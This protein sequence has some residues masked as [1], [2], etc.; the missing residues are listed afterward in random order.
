MSIP[1]NNSHKLFYKCYRISKKNFRYIKNRKHHRREFFLKPFIKDFKGFF[2]IVHP[3]WQIIRNEITLLIIIMNQKDTFSSTQCST[4]Q[5]EFFWW[6]MLLRNCRAHRFFFLSQGMNNK[7]KMEKIVQK[8]RYSSAQ[9][10][11]YSVVQKVLRT[12][13][14]VVAVIIIFAIIEKLKCHQPD[15]V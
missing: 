8:N 5:I 9:K 14:V 1:I 6:S 4:I 10:F 3:T 12:P 13:C 15:G 11:Q 2:I 7:L